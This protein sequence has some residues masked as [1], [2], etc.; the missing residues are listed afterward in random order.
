MGT[1]IRCRLGRRSEAGGALGKIVVLVAV[2]FGVAVCIGMFVL[3]S[4]GLGMGGS[5]A[6][7]ATVN[8][9][10]S[11]GLT[12]QG[13]AAVNPNSPQGGPVSTSTDMRGYTSDLDVDALNAQLAAKGSA[14]AGQ[15]QAI[16]DV[17]KQYNLDPAVFASLIMEESGWG[18]NRATTQY[19]DCTSV[20]T[21][22]DG[23]QFK[24]FASPQAAMQ[25]TANSLCNGSYY[26]SQGNTTLGS[27]G[28][29]YA[30][31]GASNDPN[32]TN[33]GWASDIATIANNQIPRKTPAG[34]G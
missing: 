4:G 31:A 8:G 3:M 21:G 23:S 15:A 11:T 25:Y 28:A 14:L 22:P 16:D 13:A 32:G 18:T 1:K 5:Q 20:M 12:Q 33:A 29:I 26:F 10:T 6:G 2:C 9:Q 30:P 19:N 24:Q 27:V 17:A 34:G 7:K